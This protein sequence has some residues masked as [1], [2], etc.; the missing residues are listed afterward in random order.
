MDHVKTRSLIVSGKS[1]SQEE[2]EKNEEDN[3]DERSNQ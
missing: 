2:N 3:G 1:N